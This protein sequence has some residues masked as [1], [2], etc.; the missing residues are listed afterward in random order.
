MMRRKSLLKNG[1]R[2]CLGLMIS[3]LLIPLQA[4]D[5]NMDLP[6]YAFENVTIHKADG[7]IIKKG[8]IVWRDGVITNMGKKADIP[9]DAMVV[10][11]GDSLHV[12]P[13][14]I[15]GMSLMGSPDQPKK[16]EKVDAPGNP[17][18][19]RA[20]VQPE[21]NP[22]EMVEEDK[23][24]V[25]AQEH[26]FTTAA[27][28]LRGEMIPGQIDLFMINGKKTGD[29]LSRERLG[30]LSQ[31]KDA[32]SSPG[33]VYP[34][35]KM[36]VLALYRQVWFDA[37]ALRDHLQYYKAHPEGMKPP[38]RSQALEAM[39]PAINKEIPVFFAVDSDIDTERIVKL[40]N[41][42]D[43][44]MVM[45]S[46]EEAYKTIDLLKDH[47]IPVL[48]SF[49]LPEKPAWKKD[50]KEE[51]DED[52]KKKKKENKVKEEPLTE[53]EKAHRKRQLE[54]YQEAVNNVKQLV[55]AGMKPGFAS[56][57][58][59]MKDFQKN[60]KIMLENGLTESQLLEIL[61][62]NTAQIL[63][64]NDI[65]G[66]LEEGNLASFSV[67]TKPFTEKKAKVKYSVSGG[68]ITEIKSKSKKR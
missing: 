19:N 43:F 17:P 7:E 40:K 20:G 48:A 24:F 38:H 61:T 3:G 29:Y 14:F 33:P 8:V 67:F 41:E 68:E 57:G 11:G 49:D 31:L 2:V 59:A 45:V 16:R 64:I 42:L 46:G 21:R 18:L 22:H 26:G 51:D 37:T 34:S 66:E 60:V 12:Y 6:A 53:D 25:T 35:S 13:G 27:L 15:D 28:G 4:Q 1:I 10:D 55:E 47:N 30:I 56:D 32:A 62:I 58:L 63:G 44:K 36:G 65:T 23:D 50:D 5:V 39:I 52:K 9:F 54:A